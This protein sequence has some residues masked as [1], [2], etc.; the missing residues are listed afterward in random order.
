MTA[1]KVS[2]VMSVYNGERYLRE[3]VESILNQ[4]FIDFEFVIIDDGSTDDTLGILERYTDPRIR[5]VKNGR[6][7][8]LT[9]SLNRGIRLARGKYVARQDADDISLPERLSSQLLFLDKHRGI[10]LV[11]TSF[12][13]I[14]SS[15]RLCEQVI[16][17]TDNET[18]QE[19]LWVRNCFCHGSVM[20][21]KEY[22]DALGELWQRSV[23]LDGLMLTDGL[24]GPE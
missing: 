23:E 18:L 21:R 22:L 16:L 14:D 10:G 3:A 7:I 5:L 4:T 2:V 12:D 17:P 8:G 24:Q 15:G 20:M 13:I 1:P 11:G 9:E 6:N 19:L